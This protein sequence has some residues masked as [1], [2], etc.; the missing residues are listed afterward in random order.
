MSEVLITQKYLSLYGPCD[1]QHTCFTICFI[2]ME[3]TRNLAGSDS[4][5]IY[6]SLTGN[7]VF[8]A[9]FIMHPQTPSCTYVY[10]QEKLAGRKNQAYAE[11]GAVSLLDIHKPQG[12][13][14]SAPSSCLHTFCQVTF[15]SPKLL[16]QKD[17]HIFTTFLK[18]N[19][20]VSPVESLNINWTSFPKIKTRISN[21]L[22]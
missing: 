5:F 12:K 11:M 14:A 4:H 15:R 17:A 3:P 8:S 1:I 2:C 7:Q 10:W 20:A 9:L 18:V 21:L 16:A 19:S 22:V 13:S 6:F